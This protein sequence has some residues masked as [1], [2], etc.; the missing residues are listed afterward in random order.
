[1]K[2]LLLIIIAAAIYAAINWDTL[3]SKIDSGIDNATQIKQ[4]A[5]NLQENVEDTMDDANDK[6]DDAKD[7]MDDASDAFEKLID[8]VK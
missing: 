5:D 6:I 2:F 3:S 4:K 8:K 1:M 7:K